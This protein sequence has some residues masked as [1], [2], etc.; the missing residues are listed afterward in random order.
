M[1]WRQVQQTALEV[2]TMHTVTKAFGER[3]W[4]MMLPPLQRMFNR[5]QKCAVTSKERKF[6]SS[7]PSVGHDE[8]SAQGYTSLPKPDEVESGQMVLK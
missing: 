6:L 8:L 2:C 1:F 7:P 5:D 3:L 4:F